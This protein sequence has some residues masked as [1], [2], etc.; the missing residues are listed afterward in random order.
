MFWEHKQTEKVVQII[1]KVMAVYE[2]EKKNHQE[3]TQHLEASYS[4]IICFV[5]TSHDNI[6]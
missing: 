3:H 4:M 6:L 2:E 1:T 5:I